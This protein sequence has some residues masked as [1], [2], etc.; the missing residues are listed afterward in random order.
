MPGKLS[1]VGIGPGGEEHLTARA[2]ELIE[3]SNVVV[4]YTSYIKL[5]EELLEGKE[6][7]A[8]GM[9]QEIE[10]AEKAL[11]LAS[12]GKKVVIVSSGDAGVY[13][14]ASPVLELMA[15]KKL[16]I[17]VEVIPGVTSALAAS[18]L[19]GAPLGHDFAVISLSDLLTPWEVIEKRLHAAGAGDFVV[20]L[21]NPR[22]KKRIKQIALARDILLKY[23]SEATPVGIVAGAYRENQRVEITTLG[24]MLAGEIDML[25]TVVIGNSQSFV[26]KNWIITPRGYR[27]EKNDNA[28]GRNH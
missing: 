12:E 5:I 15:R 25:T 6:V 28:S 8:S 21:Y 2:R 16:E 23:R 7:L 10:R 19:L 24:E 17:D 18:A 13:G 3:K 4:G 20:A 22:S 26:Y 14:M 27:V 1:I 9:R 11:S